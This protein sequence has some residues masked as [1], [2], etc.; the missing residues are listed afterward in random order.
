MLP[1]MLIIT[2]DARHYIMLDLP[3]S[4]TNASII[5]PTTAHHMMKMVMMIIIN[6][7]CYQ[8]SLWNPACLAP[9]PFEKKMNGKMCVLTRFLYDIKSDAV[10]QVQQWEKPKGRSTKGSFHHRACI[11]ADM[12]GQIWCVA[13]IPSVI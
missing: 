6:R 7:S 13:I 8:P 1:C 9:A 4:P 12:S 11:T 10:I 3:A 2:A 5:N